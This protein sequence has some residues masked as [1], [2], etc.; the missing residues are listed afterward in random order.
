MQCRLYYAITLFYLS[1]LIDIPSSKLQ[2][3][4]E[5]KIWWFIFHIVPNVQIVVQFA[6]RLEIPA[7]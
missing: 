4:F 7:I 6:F 3:L 1:Q 2:Q 5:V